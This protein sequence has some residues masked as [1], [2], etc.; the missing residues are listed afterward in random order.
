MKPRVG[1]RHPWLAVKGGGEIDGGKSIFGVGESMVTL[2]HLN[3]TF[4]YYYILC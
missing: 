3:L 2:I 1:E 4:R